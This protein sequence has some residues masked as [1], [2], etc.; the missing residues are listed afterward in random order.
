M[1]IPWNWA[2]VMTIKHNQSIKE[3]EMEHVRTQRPNPNLRMQGQEQAKMVRP[4]TR[5]EGLAHDLETLHDRINK[6]ISQ[7]RATA[8][9]LVGDCPPDPPVEDQ[10]IGRG[11]T[12]QV[13][14]LSRACRVELDRLEEQITRFD[15]L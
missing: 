10:E 5:L 2:A 6:L 8:D 9:R 13:E 1:G 14:D 4:A 11:L 7:A 3:I 15:Q 12:G